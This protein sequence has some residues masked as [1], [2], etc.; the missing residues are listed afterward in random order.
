[1]CIF[2]DQNLFVVFFITN[3]FISNLAFGSFGVITTKYLDSFYADFT[4][5]Q[6]SQRMSSKVVG[7]LVE[8]FL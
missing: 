4:N 8:C 2:K 3:F 5:A 7:Y 6:Y 1:M